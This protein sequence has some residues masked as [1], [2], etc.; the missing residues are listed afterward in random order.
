M[1]AYI[2]IAMA[3]F[4]IANAESGESDEEFLRCLNFATLTSIDSPAGLA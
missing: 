4:S 2:A 1:F 3:L